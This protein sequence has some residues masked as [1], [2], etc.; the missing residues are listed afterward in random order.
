[1]DRYIDIDEERLLKLHDA[2]ETMEMLNQE[3]MQEFDLQL[4]ALTQAPSIIDAAKEAIADNSDVAEEDVQLTEVAISIPLGADTIYALG[5]S[6]IRLRDEDFAYIGESGG[7]KQS[8]FS[9]SNYKPNVAL[10]ELTRLAVA[11]SNAYLDEFLTQYGNKQPA[12]VKQN[13][14]R[15]EEATEPGVPTPTPAPSAAPPAPTPA[16]SPPA[17][18]K[19][20]S[21]QGGLKLADLLE[22]FLG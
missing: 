9:L 1:M 6:G 16:A 10:S 8:Y 12:V 13:V 14:H 17:V 19:Q 22:N 5:G 2:L 3:A 20:T 11:S 4:F 7:A 18:P 15:T 21:L